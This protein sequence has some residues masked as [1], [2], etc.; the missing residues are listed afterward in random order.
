[1]LFQWVWAT[2]YCGWHAPMLH[3]YVTF[4]AVQWTLSI[5][6]WF[7]FCAVIDHIISKQYAS[8][9][10]NKTQ[11]NGQNHLELNAKIV[12]LETLCSIK[13]YKAEQWCC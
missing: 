8:V 6:E 11:N 12:I 4:V 9:H 13:L 1:M 2:S 10:A 3:K 7:L 5:T